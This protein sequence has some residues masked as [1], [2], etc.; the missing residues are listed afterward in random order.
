MKIQKS[1]KYDYGGISKNTEFEKWYDK[2]KMKKKIRTVNIYIRCGMVAAVMV[3]TRFFSELLAGFGLNLLWIMPLIGAAALVTMVYL[4]GIIRLI[5]LSK[6]KLDGKC[7]LPLKET[8][9][10]V[11]NGEITRKQALASLVLPLVVFAAV[12]SAAAIFTGG[13]VRYSF[14]CLLITSC[15]SCA[16]D[17]AMLIHVI[18]NIEKN[19]VIYGE[20]KRAK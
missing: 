8:D 4:R 3:V 5:P 19:A 9:W 14:L 20:Y 16:T 13:M 6:G 15:A 11:Y 7:I 18:R 12:F 17:V 2:D 10:A 1:A